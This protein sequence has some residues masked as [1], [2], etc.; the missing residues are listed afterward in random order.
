ML[1]RSR[2][3]RSLRLLPIT[4][5]VL[6]FSTALHA[7]QDPP[8]SLGDVARKLREEKQKNQTPSKAAITNDDIAAGRVLGS[9]GAAIPGRPGDS[10]TPVADP[11]VSFDR[12]EALIRKVQAMDQPTLL[13]LALQGNDWNFPGRH[14]WEA[15]L[16]QARQVYV[17]RGLDLLRQLR[18]SWAAAKALDASQAGG[19]RESDPRAQALLG[20][21]KAL[22]QECVRTDAAFQAV[23]LEGRD[24][25]KQSARP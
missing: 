3:P 6:S 12:T 25:A 17:A 5:L 13:N 4:I 16:F 1:S 7:Q 21:I 15:R 20:R 8:P 24:L 9:A 10:G 2:I 11:T 14:D 22:M 18:Q 23:F 19:V